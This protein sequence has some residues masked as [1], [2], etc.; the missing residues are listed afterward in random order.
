MKATE[1]MKIFED[2]AYVRMGGSEEELRAANYL[3]QKCAEMGLDAKLE[4]FDVDMADIQQATLLVDGKEIPCKG[5]LCAGSGEVEA[6][7]Y[8]LRS[9]DPYSLSLCKGKIVMID[10]Y[11][12]YWMYQDLLENGAVGFITY[13]GNANYTDS[14]IDQREL[15]SYVSKGNKILGVNIN[16]KSAIEL[17]KNDA[18]TAK[19]ILKQNEYTGKSHNVILDLP[20]ERLEYIVMTAHYD[21]TSLS[22]GTYDNMSGS[23]G[24]LAAAEYFSKNPHSYGLRFIWCGSEERGLLGAKAYCRDHEEELKDIVLNVNLDMIGCIM[25][26]FIACCTTEEALTHYI[27]YLCKELGFGIAVKQDV[28]SSDSTPFADKGIPAVSF[29]RIAPPNTATIHN[30][31]DTIALMKGEQMEED[32]RFI[33]TFTERMANA[34][35]C[36]VAREIPDNMKEKLDIYL[37]RKRD[38]K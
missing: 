22:Q 23:V 5:Y 36:P 15:R 16:A 9:T 24:I 29:A 13:D 28:Y 20:G 27:K 25:G 26:K 8:Y 35:M 6:P 37:T 38:K 2:T 14:D 4:A 34:A 21:S 7:L 32:I 19:I 33:V 18:A 31:Y 3:A 17:I 10:V 12:G 30:S 1:I 11:L